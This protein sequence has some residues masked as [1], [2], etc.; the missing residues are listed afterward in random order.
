MEKQP[1][2]L[3]TMI[4]WCGNSRSA[5]PRATPMETMD[6]AKLPWSM[7]VFF[8]QR[9]DLSLHR[10]ICREDLVC[11]IYWTLKCHSKSYDNCEV[12]HYYTFGSS[13]LK[14]WKEVTVCS[15]YQQCKV[16]PGRVKLPVPCHQEQLK[17][18]EPQWS[19]VLICR[20]ML[21]S[22]PR[23]LAGMCQGRIYNEEDM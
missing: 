23:G 21:L 7:I 3:Q 22:I 20:K 17:G 13:T 16:M 15:Y 6:L 9:N 5:S 2:T 19:Q 14:E 4:Y 8:G 12:P 1:I 11:S 18:S 10:S